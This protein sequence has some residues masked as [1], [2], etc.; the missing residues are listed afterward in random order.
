M[1]FFCIPGLEA[2]RALSHK[3]VKVLAW[4]ACQASFLI[5][6]FAPVNRGGRGDFCPKVM[7]EVA[8]T[9]RPLEQVAEEVRKLSRIPC[10][11]LANYEIYIDF[12]STHQ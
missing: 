9:G 4:M 6:P 10:S 11:L 5:Y 2:V 7:A 12:V 3:P 8:R 1:Q